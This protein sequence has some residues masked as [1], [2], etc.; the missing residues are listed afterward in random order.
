MLIELHGYAQ[1]Q[2][3][4]VLTLAIMLLAAWLTMSTWMSGN[5]FAV[6]TLLSQ[7]IVGMTTAT[8]TGGVFVMSAWLP[9]AYVQVKNLT[10]AIR[11]AACSMVATA[12]PFIF[13]TSKRRGLII[14]SIHNSTDDVMCLRSVMRQTNG[15]DERI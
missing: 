7:G 1:V 13:R 2:Y 3:P 12:T 8:I 15:E 10:A 6:V 9:P 4:N 11:S 5:A 14:P